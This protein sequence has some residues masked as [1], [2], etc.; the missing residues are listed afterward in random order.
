MP[1]IEATH[2]FQSA[3]AFSN[4]FHALGFKV[5]TPMQCQSEY[6]LHSSFNDNGLGQFIKLHC[7]FKATAHNTLGV[8]GA[9]SGRTGLASCG[10]FGFLTLLILTGFG[11]RGIL[12]NRA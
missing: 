4:F 12:P 6:N 5:V 8:K 9:S 10:D 1:V 7:Q 3:C 2:C 11:L